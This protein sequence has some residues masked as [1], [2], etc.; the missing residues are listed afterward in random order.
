MSDSECGTGVDG[1]RRD[2][3]FQIGE[4]AQAVGLSLKTIRYYDELGIVVPSARSA[5]G[6]RLY[7]RSDIE[8]FL[9]IKKFKPLGFPLEAVQELVRLL[10]LVRDDSATDDDRARLEGFAQDAEERCV[11][12]RAQLADAELIAANIRARLVRPGAAGGD[13]R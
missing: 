12:L 6:F 4:L 3:L 11:T 2:E 5:G 1:A 8:R 13:D 10:D 9:F 7:T